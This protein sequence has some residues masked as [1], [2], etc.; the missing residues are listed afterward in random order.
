MGILAEL[1]SFLQF[2][3]GGDIIV[4]GATSVTFQ[5]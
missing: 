2:T 3:L 4:S 1:F 5:N